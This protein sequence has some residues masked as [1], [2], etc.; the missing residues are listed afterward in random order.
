MAL[1]SRSLITKTG[2]STTQ[3]FDMGG[4]NIPGGDF[5][6]GSA[7]KLGNASGIITCTTFSGSGASLTN[8]PAGN[9][10]GTVA[11]A[12]ISALTASKLSGAL[13]AIS[14]ANL[15]N[16]P[17]ANLTGTASAINGSNITNL[18]G[19]N[20]SSGIVTSARLGGGTASSSTFLRGDGTFQVVNTDL[21]AD[22]SPQLGGN[23]DVNTKNI[24]FGDSSGSSDDRLN[25]GADTDLSIY[26]NGTNN[27]ISSNT[28]GKQLILAANSEVRLTG[29]VTRVMDE[30]NTETC[31]V[32]QPDGKVELYHDNNKV[33][34]THASG[35]NISSPTASQYTSLYIRGIASRGAELQMI[36]NNGASDND[37]WRFH[38][39]TNNEFRIE[40]YNGSSW[41]TS[42]LAIPNSYTELRHDAST[43]LKTTSGGV[44]VYNSGVSTL[45]IETGDSR[46]Q[47]WNILSTNGANNNTGTLSI[48]NEAGSSFCDFSAN[49]GSPKTTFRNGG[50][51]D[52]LHID[53]DG[54]V[55]AAKQVGFHATG[56]NTYNR[57]SA[58]VPEFN[59]EY[60]DIGGGYNHTNYRFTAPVAGRYFLYFQYLTYPNA[61]PDWKTFLFRKNGS[62][63]GLYDQGFYRG[64]EGTHGAQSSMQ[65]STYIQLAAN[66][67]IEPY[68]ETT[69]GGTF[70]NY[71]GSGHSHFWGFL[72][73]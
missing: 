28:S 7:I 10:T 51:N 44:Q 24:N 73:H 2:I 1:S 59:T 67:Y 54:N 39:H 34:E 64:H 5:N 41:E 23:L 13:P 25:F 11:D 8:L 58:F 57:S 66:D 56:N 17:A 16:I 20:I 55:M 30:N 26:H 71:M 18:N 68:V 53:S 46:G 33:V 42:I 6:I 35:L 69:G 50:A 27:I 29:T 22:T 31:A 9:L 72:V 32:F 15:T 48:R 38:Q 40:N 65:M 43:R 63:S 36:A 47:A 60:F 61:D 19:S 45:Q 49:A 21:V 3:V 52:L 70:Y 4:I 62:S 37:Y 14:A 12:R